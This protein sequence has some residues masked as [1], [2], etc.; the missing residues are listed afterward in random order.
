MNREEKIANL[1]IIM[2]KINKKE[3]DIEKGQEE[4]KELKDEYEL[5]KVSELPILLFGIDTTAPFLKDICYSYLL[6]YY[7]PDFDEIRQITIRKDN[8]DLNRK[9]F[10][11]NTIDLRRYFKYL[12]DEK[13]QNE[14]LN[15]NYNKIIDV[16]TTRI[17]LITDNAFAINN[18]QSWEEVRDYIK[19][20]YID[21][22]ERELG[23]RVKMFL[24]KLSPD[25][26]RVLKKMMTR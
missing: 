20:I 22:R 5:A 17:K 18:F 24:E 6:V 21:Q 12:V 26:K 11:P 13:K 8:Q 9:D 1:E 25:E 19:N 10:L 23:D 14:L 16:A 3:Q 2:E 15:S 4:L 7:C